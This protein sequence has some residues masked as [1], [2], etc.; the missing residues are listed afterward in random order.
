MTSP[1]FEPGSSP[2][3]VVNE[4]SDAELITSV[5]SGD[6]SAFDPLYRRHV[7]AARNLARQLTRSPAEV[8][9]LVAEA[10]AKVL[11]TL[12]SGGGPDTAFR[13]YL[14][15]TLRNSLYDRSRR[16]RRVEYRGDVAKLDSGEPF[17]DP[18]LIALE[19]S[20]VA[21][22]FAT[23]P[24]RWQTV[25][26][27]TEVEGETPAQIAPIL[28]LTANGVSAL[29]YRAREGLRQAYL[30]MHLADEAAEQCRY[31]VE[32]LGA[33]ARG[34]LSK[35]EKSRVDAHLETC[36][37]CPVLAA[38]LVDLNR[39]LRGIVVPIVVGVPWA[40]GY[41]GL[42]GA[43][44]AA[45]AAA[46]A[47]ATAAAVAGAGTSG[48]GAG[49]AGAVGAGSAGGA[50]AGGVGAV[51]A[52]A[53]APGIAA[54][55]AAG[56]HGVSAIL[57]KVAM[58]PKN[59]R[60]AAAAGT[61]AA[62]AAVTVI[63]LLVL[64][65][66][67]K[68]NQAERP[69]GSGGPSLP[70]STELPGSS[71]SSSGSASGPGNPGPGSP[72]VAGAQPGVRIPPAGPGPSAGST[73]GAPGQTQP[74]GPT[75]SPTATRPTTQPPPP[76]TL[77]ITVVASV[78][79][80]TQGRPGVVSVRVRNTAPAAATNLDAN[81]TLSGGIVLRGVGGIPGVGTVVGTSIGTPAADGLAPV[82]AVVPG[83]PGWK[84]T[85]APAGARCTLYR[86]GAGASSTLALRVFVGRT[87]VSGLLSGTITANGGAVRATLP[88]TRL[89]VSVS[90]SGGLPRFA[91]P[92]P[93]GR[94]YPATAS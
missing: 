40:A 1:P 15:T 88:P 27:H 17:V 7:G 37:R 62:I 54:T 63:G 57:G 52:G 55:G 13:A 75:T 58:L 59:A 30:Q 81:F 18:A 6:S 47:G 35:R 2:G 43:K 90:R 64:P 39:G 24:E 84:C 25:L 9:D 92:E 68:S 67:D 61:A 33:W 29:A 14:L 87:A 31:T 83:S 16:D 45:A 5:R 44:A 19:A 60:A 11:D 79:R 28:G 8:D 86:L 76:T 77:E 10:F 4:P 78:R 94:R 65:P 72:S 23:L 48:A 66:G 50:A 71:A 70:G 12:R 85:R 41:L 32:R 89:V 82:G 53:A 38:E 46:T 80:L 51:G 22:G 91:N 42:A 36:E 93:A 34:G 69:A 21:R 73:T 49:G 26:W 56:T 20:M 74:P 3:A